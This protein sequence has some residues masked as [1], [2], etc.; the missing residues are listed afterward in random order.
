[1]IRAPNAPV[2]GHV[3]GPGKNVR[4]RVLLGLLGIRFRHF[5]PVCVTRD[6][7]KFSPEG[8]SERCNALRDDR[9][10]ARELIRDNELYA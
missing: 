10:S 8:F 3:I 6:Q 4:L 9:N 5:I 7:R 1:M 2:A